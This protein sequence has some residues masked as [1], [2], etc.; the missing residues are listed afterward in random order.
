MKTERELKLEWLS[1]GKSIRLKLIGL[2]AERQ[3]RRSRAEYAGI[4]YGTVPSKN[5]SG[6]GTQDKLDNLAETEADILESEKEL[7]RVEAEIRSA[8]ADVRKPIYQTYLRMRFLGYKTES[9]IAKETGYSIESIQGYIRKN[10]LD[11]I[12]FTPNNP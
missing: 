3:E 2:Y 6:N 5:N 1:R 12:K 9:Q 7:K 4:T 11:S 8:I 10:S